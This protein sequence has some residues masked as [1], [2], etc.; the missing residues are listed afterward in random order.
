MGYGIRGMGRCSIAVIRDDDHRLPT[1]LARGSA[2][3]TRLR[4]AL[5][6]RER[7]TLHSRVQGI[8]LWQ[9]IEIFDT[10]TAPFRSPYHVV[11]HVQ[12][13]GH[14]TPALL[15]WLRTFQKSCSHEYRVIDYL[16]LSL[17]R[18]RRCQPSCSSYRFYIYACLFPRLRFSYHVQQ[19][20][21]EVVQIGRHKYRICKRN[22]V[23]CAQWVKACD[24]LCSTRRAFRHNCR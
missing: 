7:R 3:L 18:L 6:A 9:Y 20:S 23:T 13:P 15:I 22:N 2:M 16:F 11:S 12:P 17:T 14:S 24:V 5:S 8:R 19:V 1:E 10:S 21:S 4:R